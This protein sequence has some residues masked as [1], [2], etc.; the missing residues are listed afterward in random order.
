[1]SIPEKRRMATGYWA[2]LFSVAASRQSAANFGMG[3]K[4]SDHRTT[5]GPEAGAPAVNQ[6]T[7]IS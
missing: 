3:C 5:A 7:G 2:K 6:I 4:Q 1:M